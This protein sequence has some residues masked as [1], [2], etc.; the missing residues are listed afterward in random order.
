MEG[1]EPHLG[2]YLFIDVLIDFLGRRE[3]SDTSTSVSGGAD[4]LYKLL[5]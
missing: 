1:L 5:R 3:S 2:I 4:F